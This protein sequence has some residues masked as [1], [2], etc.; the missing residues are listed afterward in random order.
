LN[1]SSATLPTVSPLGVVLSLYLTCC[2]DEGSLLGWIASSKLGF[3]SLTAIDEIDYEVP[4]IKPDSIE[5]D[6]LRN[7]FTTWYRP[8]PPSPLAASLRDG[9]LSSGRLRLDGYPIRRGFIVSVMSFTCGRS[10]IRVCICIYP[11][12]NPRRRHM[13]RAGDRRFIYSLRCLCDE[14]F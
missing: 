14:T 2:M 8:R 11:H 9:T 4:K 6:A 7:M 1:Q 5:I 12:C 3:D 13:R 10:V